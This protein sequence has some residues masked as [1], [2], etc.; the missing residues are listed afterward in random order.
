MR[1]YAEVIDTSGAVVVRAEGEVTADGDLAELMGLVV[2]RF[3][4]DH[5]NQSLM[6]DIGQAGSTV[7]LGLAQLADAQRP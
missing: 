6:M 4:R 2:N 5:P 1:M 3:R 7:R